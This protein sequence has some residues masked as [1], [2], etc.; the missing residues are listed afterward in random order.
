MLEHAEKA[1]HFV[2]GMAESDFRHDEKTIFA[3]IRALE[4]IG[5]AA[6]NIPEP[7]RNKYPHIPWR[8]VAGMR[9]KLIHHYFGVDLET[10]WKTVMKDLPLLRANL[11]AAIVQESRSS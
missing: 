11:E 8:D 7:I 3:V 6:K 4:V 5:E 9:D 2:Q 1:V 10:V